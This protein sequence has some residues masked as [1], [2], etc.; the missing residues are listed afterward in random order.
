MANF[1]DLPVELRQQVYS[2]ASITPVTRNKFFRW[3]APRARYTR[4]VLSTSLQSRFLPLLRVSRRVFLDIAPQF[5]INN[6]FRMQ[7]WPEYYEFE[8]RIRDIKHSTISNIPRMRKFALTIEFGRYT[9]CRG[10]GKGV[11]W[12]A[13]FLLRGGVLSG[14][15]QVTS[16][17][18]KTCRR[19][20]RGSAR[21]CVRAVEEVYE[22]ICAGLAAVGRLVDIQEVLIEDRV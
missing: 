9:R 10:C 20:T 8:G 12:K 22:L 2:Y 21:S 6:A 1:H 15:I 11:A 7:F 4:N 5:Y 16:E 17:H 3:I 18:S 14:L 19:D 13:E